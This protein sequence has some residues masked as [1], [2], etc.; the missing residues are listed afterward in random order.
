MLSVIADFASNTKVSSQCPDTGIQ[1]NCKQ[2]HYT[3]FSIKSWIPVSSTGMTPFIVRT[4]LTFTLWSCRYPEQIRMKVF[5]Y[6][7]EHQRGL[8]GVIRFLS[9]LAAVPSV[10]I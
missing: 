10:K 7:S 9:R 8:I 3:T 1:K 5:L 4:Y 2:T 6:L